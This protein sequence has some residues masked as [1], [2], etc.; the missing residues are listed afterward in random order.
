MTPF[1][2]WLI[3]VGLGLAVFIGLRAGVVALALVD[4]EDFD[5][6]SGS[7]WFLHEGYA[8]RNYRSVRGLPHLSMSMHRQILGLSHGDPGQTDH[9]NGNRLDNRRANLRVVTK[10]QNNQNVRH[11]VG[12]SGHRHVYWHAHSG[13]W[14]VQVQVDGRKISGGYFKDVE[15]AVAKAFLLRREHLPFTVEVAA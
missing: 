1:F 2:H 12:R 11:R 9:I 15:D 8:V 5:E 7:R 6:L 3:A 13:L 10:A 14:H 4:T